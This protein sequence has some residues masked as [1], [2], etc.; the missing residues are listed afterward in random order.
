VADP[1]AQVRREC[2]IALHHNSAADAPKLWAALA[3]E[4]DGKDRWYLEALGIGA[5][6]QEDKFFDAWLTTVGGHWNTLA[7]RDIV[8]RS[9]AS[10]S[11]DLLA[12]II[13]NE[14]TS[15]SQR[16]RYFRAF[17]F[18][19]SSEKKTALLTLLTASAP[20]DVVSETVS[21][22][23]RAEFNSNPS[24]KAAVLAA[25]KA[26]RGTAAFVQLVRE[27]ALPGENAALLDTAVR[28][29][30]EG[31]GVD[32]MRL[33]LSSGD[34]AG[35]HALLESTN[36]ESL[37]AIEAVGNT[38]QNEATSLL[39]PLVTAADRD[40]A[41]HR[42]AVRSLAQT[43]E[44]TEALLQMAQDNKLPN[45]VKFTATT[46]LN[47][48][49][50]PNLKAQA[51]KL[52]PLPQGRNTETLPPVNELV[53]RRVD[54]AHGAAVF[55]RPEST[56][57]TCHRIND[58]GGEVGPALSEIGDKLAKDAIYEAILDPSASIAFG[59]DAWQITL[60]SGDDLE[61]L[62][63]SETADEVLLK[64]AKAIATHVKKGDIATRRKL[65][66][67]L[68]PVGLQQTMSTQDLVDLV[69]YLSSLK[70]NVSAK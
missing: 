1:S 9:R 22:L 60:K 47:Q 32:A 70:K 24:V 30:S 66:T 42:Q 21:R 27:F 55:A 26:A 6:Q 12:E 52:L 19:K 69:G 20:P 51:A 40:T 23:G 68:M 18:I 39:L 63:V 31:F 13:K 49:R 7:G 15:E 43:R 28:H 57:T 67:S 48:V 38:R 37:R 11:A 41:A 56:C 54:L 10:Q 61:G 44:G 59:F 34:L 45:D 14:S 5:D 46:V 8:W 3:E 53:R 17:D 35:L 36:A 16:A 4:Y 65:K 62:I 33:V 2:A 64:D 25:V 58:K 29:P 50:W